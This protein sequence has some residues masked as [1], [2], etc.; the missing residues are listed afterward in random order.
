GTETSGSILSPAARCGLAGLR[1]T[2]GRVSRYG[3]MALSWTQDRLGPICRYAEDCAIVMQAIAKPDGRDMSVSE[4]PF[5]WNAQL[6]IKKLRV[7]YI[8]ESFDELTNA[9]ARRNAE[10]GLETLRSIGVSSFVPVIV[11]EMPVNTNGLGG[12]GVEATVFFDEYARAG[13]MKDARGGGR[14]NGRL[15]PAVD[16]LQSQRVRMMMMTK[17]AE[18]TAHVD[19][20]VVASN[21]NGR[22]PGS[23]GGAQPGRGTG[24]PSATAATNRGGAGPD[25][26]RPQTA[27]QRH[28]AMANLACYPA[29]NIPNGFSETGSPTNLTFFGRPFGEMEILA[30]AKAYQDAAGFHLKRPGKLAT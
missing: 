18:A 20:Y 29:I 3:V 5:N 2:F 4:I 25:S 1:P 17:L 21:N 27:T 13:R 9:A 12:I 6:D 16:Y 8:K 19:V 23:R 14:P 11:P 28:S 7:G 24:D 30:L 26:D 15:I 10:Q 22:G